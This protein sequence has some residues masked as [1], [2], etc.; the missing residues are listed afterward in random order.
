[1]GGTTRGRASPA[2]RKSSL[3]C[4]S[5][6]L[7]QRGMLVLLKLTYCRDHA[8]PHYDRLLMQGSAH[9]A[10]DGRHM[11]VTKLSSTGTSAYGV[12]QASLLRPVNSRQR[13]VSLGCQHES[14][15]GIYGK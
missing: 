3:K 9:E 10:G 7:Q 2:V 14:I 12:V 4:A 5:A 6:A 1:M 8:A 15:V 11:G 13:V